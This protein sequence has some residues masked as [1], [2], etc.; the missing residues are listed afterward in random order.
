MYLS[1]MINGHSNRQTVRKDNNYDKEL[2]KSFIRIKNI[3]IE[4]ISILKDEH[5]T[6]RPHLWKIKVYLML[7]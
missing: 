7:Q 5:L 6:K 2:F 4:F 3:S 1:V